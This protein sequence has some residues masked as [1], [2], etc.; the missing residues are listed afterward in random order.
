MNDFQ[1]FSKAVEAKFAA[2]S[3]GELFVVE[4]EDI[5]ASYL[6]AFPAGS[7]PIYRERTEHDCSCCKHFVR[8]LGHV[9][10]FG[11]GDKRTSIWDI[12]GLPEPYATVA[13][14]MSALVDQMPIK[15]VYRTKERQ[16]GV[17]SN[18]GLV[19][20][21]TRKFHHF[22]GQIASRHYAAEPD[23]ARS[24]LEA[25]AQVLRRGLEELKIEAFDAVLDLIDS[26]AI[27]RGAEFREQ[28][29]SFKRLVQAF[30][31]KSPSDR[32]A[33]VWDHLDAPAA[34]FR[35]TAIGTL[36]VDLSEGVKIER[37]VKSFES[38]VAPTNYKRPTALITAKMVEQ[39][40]AKLDELGLSGA[41]E[42]R[43]ARLSD[44]TVNNVLWVDNSVKGSMK[45][46]IAGLL[47]GDVKVP[48]VDLRTA[49]LI[50][51]DGFLTDVIPTATS[52]KLALENKHLS[53]FMSLTAP[54][55][56]DTGNL[57]K[58]DNNFAWS[59]DGEVTD[60]IKERVK[61]AGG[62]VTGTM[63]VSLGWHNF[64][65]LDLHVI[66]PN[67]NRI[68]F[69]NKGN[70]LDVDMNAGGGRSRDPVE[71]VTWQ[72][73]LADGEYQVI[74]NQYQRR[75]SVDVGFTLEV[76]YGGEIKQYSMPT[77]PT[78]E[79]PCLKL[80]VAGGK[81]AEVT[82]LKKMTVGSSS[83]EKWGVSSQT[84]VPVDTLMLSPNFW[85]GQAIGNKHWFFMLHGLKNP[86]ATRGIY[87]EFLRSTLD[88][89]RKVFEVLGA[90]TKC[91]P[92]DDQLSGVGFSSTRGDRATVVVDASGKSRAFNVQF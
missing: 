5:F 46:G 9:V 28:V 66:E 59:Y 56:P 12:D 62:N 47:S 15:T 40:V 74:V 3:Q 23:T 21:E 37:A 77:S 60:S 36:L 64:D 19:D 34:R 39:A 53:N 57:F 81:L 14:R 42:R 11:A 68:A 67:G 79:L 88:P 84:L 76:E 26:K 33:F 8:H 50:T 41:V 61:A 83:Q 24:N 44:V 22:V 2:M 17:A 1:A 25:V 29:A 71:N 51:M 87:N 16:F 92:A 54:V 80:G 70:K 52:I 30:A 75:E 90:R 85:D 43:F 69:Y 45:G 73:K 49:S 91:P 55:H 89:H 86:D 20:G 10:A 72:G 6:S 32:E 48:S 38:K 4:V 58:W 13:A 35:N 78:G 7:N 82:M 31:S 63:R 27:Y 18:L 65:D